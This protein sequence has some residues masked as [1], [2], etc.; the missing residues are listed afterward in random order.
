M[1]TKKGKETLKKQV[2]FNAIGLLLIEPN[3][4]PEIIY[5]QFLDRFQQGFS[6]YNLDDIL[7]ITI[8]FPPK[9]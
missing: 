9:I 4:K 5:S 2:E 7:K 1:L 6:K 8:E 3:K